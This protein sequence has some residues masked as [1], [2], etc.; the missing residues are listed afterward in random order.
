MTGQR[1]WLLWVLT[2][3]V[4]VILLVTA[5]QGG[6]SDLNYYLH[7]F[8][9]FGR[10]GWSGTLAEYPLPAV[11]LL[12][13]PYAVLAAIGHS[14]WA[15]V[16]W[17]AMML[18]ADLVVMLVVRRCGS[19]AA[20]LLWLLAT[21]ALGSF[22]YARFDLVPGLLTAVAVLAMG[23]RPRRS[24][25]FAALATALKYTPVLVLP[26]LLAA[27]RSRRRVVLVVAAVGAVTAGVTVALGG[28][29][30][31]LSPLRYQSDRG[32]QI[33]SVLASGPMLA[34]A[35]S[36]SRYRIWFA[37]SK[38]WEITGPGVATALL[39]TTAVTVLALLAL[40]W[41]WV[42]AW[43]LGDRPTTERTTW[44]ALAATLAFIV[45]GKVLSPQYL[46]WLLPVAVVGVAATYDEARA[47]LVRWTIGLLVVAALTHVVWPYAYGRLMYVGPGTTPVTLVLVIRNLMLVALLAWALVECVRVTRL[48]VDEPDEPDEPV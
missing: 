24:A 47:R 19:T 25:L 35:L 7:S 32:L 20:A 10:Y 31:L 43:R 15:P 11:L 48:P 14:G 37:P 36:P 4:L 46:G 41:L 30:R 22:V 27:H 38:S 16:A 40:I 42:R 44:L 45:S 39:V 8:R 17:V 6:L 2:R 18:V 28:A 23:D 3:A 1:T 9:D 33:E 5:E 13:A 34:R 29:D 21:P 26:A 12:I